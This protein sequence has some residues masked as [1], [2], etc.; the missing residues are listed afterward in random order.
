MLSVFPEL[1][2][3]S[4]IAPLLLRISLAIVLIRVGYLGISKTINKFEKALGETQILSGLLLF[5]GFL[6]QAVALLIIALMISEIV[7]LKVKKLEVANK[8]LKLLIFAIA[9]CLLFLG[10][11]LLSLDLPL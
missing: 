11:G 5:L 4:Q 7:F 3:Y 6:T 2:N 10:P 1:L 9:F 8:S